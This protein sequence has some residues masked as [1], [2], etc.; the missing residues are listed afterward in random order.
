MADE[1]LHG[2]EDARPLRDYVVPTV[3]GARSSIARPTV[4]ANNFEI[5]PVIIQVIQ[6]SVQFTGIL[7]DDPNAH[8]VNFFKFCDTFKQNGVSNNA[9]RLRLFP[10]SLRDKTK[11]W[12]NSL[13]AGTI[14]T[15]D[16]LA[17]KFLEIQRPI[18]K[19]STSRST[20]L[21]SGTYILQWFGI[22]YQNND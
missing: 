11:E 22:Q 14:T 9:I 17:H 18:K 15:W 8:I 10:F 5:K 12:L 13:H 21:A 2:N 4:Q 20:N 1:A 19:I 6:T 16:G 7:N 3:N